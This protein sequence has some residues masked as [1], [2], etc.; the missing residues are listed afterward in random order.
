MKRRVIKQGHNTLTITLPRKW[1]I[2]YNIKAGDELD[3]SQRNNSLVISNRSME[4]K[5]D[6]IEFDISNLDRTS[7]VILVQ[8]LYRY[9][10]D[11]IEIRTKEPFFYHYRIG[12]NV[13]VSKVVHEIVARF[14]GSEIISSSAKS[15]TIKKI[16]KESNEEFDAVLRNL[17]RLMNDKIEVFLHGL[18]KSDMNLMESIEDHHINMKKFINYCL[19][20][21][22]KFGKGDVRK[23]TFY[24]AIIQYI[25]KIEDMIK[26]AAR[27]IVTY[28]YKIGPK[29]IE[30][31]KN[32]Q[33]ALTMYYQLFYDYSLKK[34]NEIIEFRE[35]VRKNFLARIG[36]FS[37]AELA[38]TAG[39]LQILE[40]LLDMTELRMALEI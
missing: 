29:A 36:E 40:I 30:V 25:S 21:L 15:F 34:V 7:T 10:Y 20:L 2:Q 24:F 23:T 38:I 11:T 17:F 16:S 37:K 39:L 31:I 5:S 13:A 27:Y 18:E 33:K 28:K 6:S 3:V 4:P 1:A 26:N 9:G 22:N 35:Q 12:Q 32:L 14:I 19:R 8:G